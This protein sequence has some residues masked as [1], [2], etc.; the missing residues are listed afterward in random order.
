MPIRYTTTATGGSC[1]PGCHPRYEYDREQPLPNKLEPRPQPGIARAAR[2]GP[3]RVELRAKDLRGNEVRVPDATR[4]TV[5]LIVQANQEE[6]RAA[7]ATLV[8]PKN[9][10][11]LVVV[12]GGAGGDAFGQHAVISDSDG[13]ITAQLDVHG[14]PTALILDKN[15][16]ELARVGGTANSLAMKLAAYTDLAAGR[17]DVSVRAAATLPGV[18][19]DDAVERAVAAS[20]ELR[21]AER[22]VESAR[23]ADARPILVRV[24]AGD[25][26]SARAHYLLGRVLEGE[27]NWKA[28][29]QE[30]RASREL[31]SVP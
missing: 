22:L 14:W 3:A 30:Y 17:T 1:Y 18:V 20:H 15:G 2:E 7:L 8:T 6:S 28:A 5:I 16:I 27:G 23:F 4:P 13:A 24:L 31:L 19:G 9:A 11:V 12:R 29:A 10:Q 21:L 26:R 25:P